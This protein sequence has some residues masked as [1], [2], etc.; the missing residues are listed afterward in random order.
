MNCRVMSEPGFENGRPGS[1][2]GPIK[3][4]DNQVSLVAGRWIL[5]PAGI[6]IAGPGGQAL[7]PGALGQEVLLPGGTAAADAGQPAGEDSPRKRHI[8]RRI[9]RDVVVP[10]TVAFTVAF[11]TQ[12]TIAK[13]YQ[14]P[15]GSMLPT[16]QLHDRIIANRLV[17][18]FSPIQRGDVIVFEPPEALRNSTDA[19]TPFVKR[20]IA[21]A[22]DT[23]EIR[24]GLVLVN[25]EEL[26]VDLA[27]K[28][29]YIRKPE[30]VPD[31]MLFVLGDNRNES[32]D[33]HSWGF[34]PVENVIGRAELIY[35]PFSHLRL[36]GE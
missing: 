14:I 20:V 3:E 5:P 36:L 10:L 19:D 33:S 13:P 17:Y 12:A 23:V 4:D 24:E 1:S 26:H 31:G 8:A 9:F 34:V 27:T 30:T 18:H 22:G 15:S 25:G 29:T 2:Q 28:P 7:P 6:G 32:F 21:L 16:I 11:F 35:W